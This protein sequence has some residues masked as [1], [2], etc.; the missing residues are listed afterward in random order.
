MFGNDPLI[1]ST[2]LKNKLI[3]A[4]ERSVADASPA[5]R[6]AFKKLMEN[7]PSD[8]ATASI[9]NGLHGLLPLPLRLVISKQRLAQFIKDNH[10]T[11]REAARRIPD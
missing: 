2:E 1:N 3:P 11:L 6:T 10:E 8:S 5:L 4:L 9:S 7:S